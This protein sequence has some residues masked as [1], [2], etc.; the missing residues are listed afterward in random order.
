MKFLVHYLQALKGKGG[1]DTSCDDIAKL[2][3]VH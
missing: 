2:A 1:I 3:S